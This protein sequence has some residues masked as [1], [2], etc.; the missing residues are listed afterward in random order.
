MKKLLL[1]LLFCSTA[2]AGTFDVTEGVVGDYRFRGISQSDMAPSIASLVEYRDDSGLWLGNKLN[3]VSKQEY[4]NGI[5][6]EADVYGGY[7]YKFNDD[8]KI[9]VGD[10]TY[11]YPGATKYYT[12][13]V[14]AQLRVPYFTFKYY[15][16]LTNEFG[17]A[18][19][20]GTQYYSVDNYLPIKEVTLV[21]H[22][23]RTVS[24]VTGLSYNDWR[25]GPTY[26]ISGVDVSVTYYWN[27]GL[28]ADFKTANTVDGHELYHN[29]LVLGVSKSW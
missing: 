8:I 20:V 14:F 13:E 17:V 10:Y 22:A 11:N 15:R 19:T 26:N 2:H 16:S 18:G 24:P 5:G 21:S 12:N 27:S 9:F 28:S 23:G 7:H 29:A 6:G 1:I 25:V 4:N 3:T